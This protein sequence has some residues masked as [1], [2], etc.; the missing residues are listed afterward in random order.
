MFIKLKTGVALFLGLMLG[1]IIGLLTKDIFFAFNMMF[2]GGIA[3]VLIND[4]IGK[5]RLEKVMK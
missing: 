1:G 2:L 4:K 3:A 5:K